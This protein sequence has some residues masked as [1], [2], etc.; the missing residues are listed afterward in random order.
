MKLVHDIW[1]TFFCQHPHS[2]LKYA[3]VCKTWNTWNDI[4]FL[5]NEKQWIWKQVCWIGNIKI[6]KKWEDLDVS[7]FIYEPNYYYRLKL[8]KWNYGLAMMCQC[9]NVDCV[10]L[11]IEKGANNWNGGLFGACRGGN[12]DCVKLMIEKGAN[13]WNGGFY[14]ACHGGNMNCAKLMIKKGATNIS[15][16]NEYFNTLDT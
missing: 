9:G 8:S 4:P 7:D 14:D 6:I 3:N 10:K 1:W 2:K 16:F 11:M 12:M 15:V 5:I 13:D